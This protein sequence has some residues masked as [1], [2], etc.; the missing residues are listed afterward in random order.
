MSIWWSRMLDREL[1]KKTVRKW[2]VVIGRWVELV[3]IG[4]LNITGRVQEP[5]RIE[6]ST[7]RL[8]LVRSIEWIV[9][10]TNRSIN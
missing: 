2:W 1:R 9:M 3:L 7:I 4:R 6:I 8:V 5:N 10:N